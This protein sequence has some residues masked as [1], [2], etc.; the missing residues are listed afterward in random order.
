MLPV[1]RTHAEVQIAWVCL[2]TGRLSR[3]TL[4]PGLSGRRGRAACLELRRTTPI[5]LGGAPEGLRETREPPT[6]CLR[7]ATHCGLRAPLGNAVPRALPG[8]CTPRP[9][10]ATCS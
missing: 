1:S 10:P 4:D 5:R 2:L 7:V 9:T 3:R 8:P 6:S